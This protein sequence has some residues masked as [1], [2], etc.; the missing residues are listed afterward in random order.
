[1][2]AILTGLQS[3]IG[4]L[5]RIERELGGG[6]MSR[7]FLTRDVALDRN[8]VIK[9]LSHELAGD[10]STERFERE[11]RVA[12]QMQQAN[13]VPLLSAGA[14]NGQPFYV[15]P[16]VEGESLRARLASGP[17]FSLT[18]G[19]R[20]LGDIAR[21]LQYAHSR[22]I[23]HR[24]IKPENVLL[25][26]GAAVVTDFGIAK[27]IESAR[28]TSADL[29]SAGVSLGTAAYMA[30][31]Q[32]VGE[33][34]DARA[35]LYAWGVIAY[36]MLTGQHIFP[37]RSSAMQLMAAHATVAPK[38]IAQLRRDLPDGLAALV[39]LALEKD[40]NKR[41]ESAETILR[42]LDAS[43]VDGRRRLSL[44]SAAAIAAVLT[45]AIG[46][47]GIW[48][49][50][51]ADT[52]RPP[53]LVL[54][55]DFTNSTGDSV[56]TGTFE[57][58]V[59]LS[60]EGAPFI[61]S[62]DRAVAARIA[63]RLRGESAGL[64]FTTAVLVAQ[65]EGIHVIV[66]GEILRDEDR[67]T[68]RL[69]AIDAATQDT[70]ESTSAT[71]SR[72]QDIL[73]E[74]GKLTMRL[75]RA[76]GDASP[77]AVQLAAAET[78][79][80]TSVD[81]AHAY[82]QAQEFLRASRPESAAVYFERAIQLDT[83]FGRAYAGLTVAYHTLGDE[84][85]A[86]RAE[87]SAQDH[88]EGL[89]DR[90][91]Y[92]SRATVYLRRRDYRAA[93]DELSRLVAAYPSDGAGW[94]N[95]A[96]A[97]FYARDFIG[98]LQ[99]ARHAVSIYPRDLLGRGNLALFA[100]YAGDNTSAIDVAR[101]L[102]A[103]DSLSMSGLLVSAMAAVVEGRHTEA[104][105]IYRRM[106]R[107][108]GRVAS[109]GAIGLADLLI[110]QGRIADAAQLLEADTVT[111]ITER[112][113]TA[114]AQKIVLLADIRFQQGRTNEATTLARRAHEMSNDLGVSVSAARVFVRTMQMDHAERIA[115][116]LD[117][118]VS[119]EARAYARVIQ[120][121]IALASGRPEAALVAL[122]AAQE[123]ADTWLGTRL[124][125]D[126]FAALGQT[127][128][129]RGE[130]DKCIRRKGEATALYFDDIPS[131]REMAGM[132]QSAAVGRPT[133]KS[134]RAPGAS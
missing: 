126:V 55:A 8:V 116:T 53:L 4:D 87:Q 124:K 133:D 97:R 13:I 96:L 123:L 72:R 34:V 127:D 71:V 81:A 84:E 16:F 39:M 104:D 15:M 121:D 22:G 49:A 118:S 24:D 129:A 64:D 40:P 37:S 82:A 23:V 3:A 52:P 18:E 132:A 12:A 27:A 88:V 120:A 46:G 62:F 85:R 67:L 93:T 25:S 134:S 74:T 112:R 102:L 94:N 32:A 68:I 77:E 21:A 79:T 51:R 58:L 111:D 89:T 95:L 33:D 106:L 28:G 50:Q 57:P 86:Q 38:H 11:I 60:L 54:L 69:N 117:S 44:R 99:N 91:R 122:R 26:G 31:E 19:V 45:I 83:S 110:I 76:L 128:A 61:S 43:A 7:V 47:L 119:I 100:L 59:A 115:T 101:E 105:S 90:E 92:R 5:F 1:M 113:A 56:I 29:T 131:Y 9:I 66:S 108:Q 6:G 98:A 125:G 10:L 107:I 30:P 42:T 63:R 48:K 17:P 65:R 73:G 75:R 103:D 41:V 35:D 14:A 80:S 2:D 20:I 109:R 78:Y 36:E 130:Y 70:I 114:A